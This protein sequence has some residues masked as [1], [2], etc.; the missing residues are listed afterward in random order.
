MN[1]LLAFF[2]AILFIILLILGVLIFS[3]RDFI[4]K[5]AVEYLITET[6][7]F[8]TEIKTLQHEWPAKFTLRGVK[9]YNP[10]GYTKP[11]FA[12]S[13]YFYI[14]FDLRDI[15][16]RKSFHIRRWSLIIRELHLEKNKQG[17]TNG[18]LL[19]SIKKLG[20]GG[21]PSGAPGLS[22]QMDRLEVQIQKITYRDRTGV[23][24]KTISTGLFLPATIYENVTDFKAMVYQIRDKVLALAGPGKIVM[25]SPF[26]LEGSL[27]KA[28]ERARETTAVVTSAPFKVVES[29]EKTPVVAKTGELLKNTAQGVTDATREFGRIISAKSSPDVA[30]KMLNPLADTSPSPAP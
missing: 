2:A 14:D 10:D 24:R 27:K 30:E 29:A 22:F 17:I 6:T 8:R 26:V 20:G 19:K 11:L 4:L 23:L 13:P 9:M 15:F 21:G 12:I 7:D 28:A 3:Y 16:E 25:L 18:T 1:R 5:I